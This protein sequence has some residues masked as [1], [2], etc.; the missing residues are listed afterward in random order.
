MTMRR[1]SSLA[2]GSVFLCGA[3]LAC[4]GEDGKNGATGAPG[5]K[6][7]N[8]SNGADGRNGVDG[9]D[10][11]DGAMGV[12]GAMGADGSDG[13]MGADGSDG[14][15]GADGSDGAMGADGSDG[16]GF[17]PL[18][19]ASAP[20]PA[21]DAQ[22][23]QILTS[24]SVTANG[25]EHAFPYNVLARSGDAIG[26]KT[27]GLLTDKDGNSLKNADDSDFISNAADF[28]SLLKVGTKLFSVTQFESLPGGMYLS[29]LSQD[30]ATGALSIKSTQPIDF[31]DVNGLWNPCAGSVSPW[32]TH[33]GSEEYPL[34]ARNYET[35]ATLGDLQYPDDVKSMSRYY[36]VDGFNA[37][38]TIA[39]VRAV[40]NPYT[41][42]H[43]IEINVAENGSYTVAKHYS[44]GRM[45]IELAKVM[46]DQKTVYISD[47]GENVGF[48]MYVA[49]TAG[50]LTA[51]TLYA[52]HWIQTGKTP[53]G[54]G[55][56]DIEW[57]KLGHA[58][59]TEIKTLLDGD[60]QFSEI[61]D[62]TAPE[63]DG[64][65]A[66][67]KLSIAEK[68]FECL[69]VKTGMEK[70][71]AFLETR[72]YASM[73]GATVEL[74]KEEGIA[75]DP[76]TSTMYVAIS[77]QSK[78]MLDA[79][80]VFDK[81][82][83][84][85]IKLTKNSCGV[86]YALDLVPD[87]AVGSDWVAANFR[88]IVE[89]SPITYGVGSPYAGNTCSINGIAN[90]DNLTFAPEYG[91]LIIG[92]DTGSGHQN[93]AVWAYDTVT[94]KKTRIM[95]TPY[96][97]ETTS[98]YWH[99]NLNDFAYLTAVVQH[100]YGESDTDKVAVDSPDRHA[101]VGVLGPLPA[102]P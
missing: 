84:N 69:T 35:A 99:P 9:K 24:A 51:G 62:A 13:A 96:G 19:F 52:M 97:A 30:A 101:Y 90:P 73:L 18:H 83:P 48:F 57:I 68:R 55:L 102:A 22:K 21:T 60:I 37:A 53:T 41:A 11:S 47:D 59:D 72:R 75:L 26:G 94:A 76:T 43:V 91:T 63:A 77:D 100:P 17:A 12:D 79:D 7:A 10:G 36:G 20:F 16:T 61:F 64:S 65:C 42:G 1:F 74:N 70:A 15:M 44:M 3:V 88:A 14:A 32:G 86:V 54:G 27:F 95:T 92:E 2:L 78:G 50:A 5:E 4:S 38:T 89:G 28:T 45:A 34:D 93:D 67:G 31:S 49:D 98:V 87:A 80:A 85:D 6:G 71:A 8:G 25:S 39:D 40:F 81:G 33:L 58:S 66:T 82:G 29:E 46:P 23:R 56:A